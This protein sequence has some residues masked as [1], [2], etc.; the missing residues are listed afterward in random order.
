MTLVS[1]SS[2]VA[3]GKLVATPVG[4]SMLSDAKQGVLPAI[5]F[6]LAFWH[7]DLGYFGRGLR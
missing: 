4:K 3:G 1:A 5:L 6:R 2:P 7:M